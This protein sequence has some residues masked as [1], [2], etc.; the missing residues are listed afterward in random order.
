MTRLCT[1]NNQKSKYHFCGKFKC[2]ISKHTFFYKFIYYGLYKAPSS[3][4][5]LMAATVYKPQ[6]I[7]YYMYVG[8]VY[9]YLTREG[10]RFSLQERG[11]RHWIICRIIVSTTFDSKSWAAFGCQTLFRQSSVE[12]EDHLNIIQQPKGCP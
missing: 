2:L 12:T 8:T 1:C 6:L 11:K 9:A 5:L 4:S 7:D 3:N 10:L